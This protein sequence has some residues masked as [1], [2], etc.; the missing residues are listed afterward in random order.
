MSQTNKLKKRCFPC[1][2]ALSMFSIFHVFFRKTCIP[3]LWL[4]HLNTLVI[5]KETELFVPRY[6]QKK[7]TF[8]ELAGVP[9]SENRSR[10]WRFSL[11]L[12]CTSRCRRKVLVYTTSF[13]CFPH[14]HRTSAVSQKACR[15]CA[16]RKKDQKPCEMYAPLL[17]PH[18]L[19]WSLC[20]G[21]VEPE[22]AAKFY[23]QSTYY[24]LCANYAARFELM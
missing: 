14:L 24:L 4:P 23:Q 18:S 11:P 5:T 19:I 21:A 15:H 7:S 1:I 22:A 13:L 9:S 12:A 6:F 16:D 8:C 17:R 20:Y 10:P 2:T 3:A